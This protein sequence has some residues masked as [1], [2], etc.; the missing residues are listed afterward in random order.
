MSLRTVSRTVLVGIVVLAALMMSSRATYPPSSTWSAVGVIALLL[1]VPAALIAALRWLRPPTSTMMLFTKRRL[2]RRSGGTRRLAFEWI[3]LEHISR[4]MWLAAIAAEDGYFRDHS[5]FD[6]Q[7]IRD[8]HAHNRTHAHKRGGSTI[9]Q[10]V[11]KNLFLWPKRSYVR[12]AMEAYFTALIEALWPKRR[13]L[14]V[15]LN[16]A[17]FGEDVFG[18]Q[19]AARRYFEKP[20]KDLSQHEAALLAAAL[21]NPIRYRVSSP[22]HQLR[23]RQSWVLAA[24]RRLGDLYLESL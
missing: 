24:M 5:G 18:V 4:D 14:E 6:W 9:T 8:A 11:A 1:C 2:A 15:Y 22:S 23:F 13:I 20:A 10:Q 7:S 3:A 17:Q 21:P 19:V 12:K 16:I